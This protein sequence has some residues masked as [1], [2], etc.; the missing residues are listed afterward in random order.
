MLWFRELRNLKVARS[1]VHDDN[2]LM[3]NAL[4]YRD[5]PN[6]VKHL[7]R[8]DYLLRF[9]SAVITIKEKLSLMMFLGIV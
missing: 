1:A 9:H 8:Y 4:L 6:A 3:I 2:I 5:L 7:W